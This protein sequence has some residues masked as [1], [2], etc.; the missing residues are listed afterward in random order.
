MSE[1]IFKLGILGGGLN[2]IA[3]YP[4]F[5]ASQM[6]RRFKI[7]AGV[8]S[9]D[10]AVNSATAKY[11]GVERSYETIDAFFA[12]EA[13]K[14]DAVTVLLP[15][16]DHFQAVE[17][18]IK[19]DIPVICEKPL[20]STVAEFDKLRTINGLADKFL[21][22]T[23]NY[24]AYPILSELRRMIVDGDF[25][26]IINMHFEMPQESFMNPP[27]S[28]DYPPAWRKKDG[29]IP[30]VLLDLLSHLFSISHYV[31]GKSISKLTSRFN[32]FSQFRVV[33]DVKVIVDYADDAAGFFWVSKTA[34]G[35]R[36]GL[37]FSV[38]G[39]KASASWVQENP[40]KLFVYQKNGS[41]QVI[42]RGN[43]P[44]I[45]NV[46][47][48][49]RMTPGHPSGYIEAFANLYCEIAEALEAYLSGADYKTNPLI[50]S[51]EKEDLNFRFLSAVV[52]SAAQSQFAEVIR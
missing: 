35:S 25:G 2:S 40:E 43:S 29:P 3:G 46:K 32:R 10:L 42:D 22:V 26:K 20:F 38:F 17:R 21:V 27:K 6:D 13:G 50:W 39:E 30:S 15:T 9:E 49:N 18:L 19:L 28:V 16:P 31:S 48:Y 14:L 41:A 51:F 11:W 4:H 33:D 23:Y 5:V 12:S 44:S 7:E 45:S 1:R 47:I 36:N 52:N 8:F 34:L 24:I 37:K